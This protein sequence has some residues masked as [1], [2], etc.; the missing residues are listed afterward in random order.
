MVRHGYLSEQ[1]EWREVSVSY[2]LL[3]DRSNTGEVDSV[4]EQSG[5]WEPTGNELDQEQT[6]EHIVEETESKTN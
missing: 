5:T 2:G 3:K 1:T 4:V 6:K